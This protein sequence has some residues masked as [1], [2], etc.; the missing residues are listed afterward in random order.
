M[1]SRERETKVGE[2]EEKRQREEIEGRDGGRE[3][4]R[5]DRGKVEKRQGERHKS[6]DE[7]KETEG[8]DKIPKLKG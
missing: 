6:I 1:Y 4:Q 3:R 2:S 8:R 5:K 7:S